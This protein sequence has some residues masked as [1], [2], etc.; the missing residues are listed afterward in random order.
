MKRQQWC[1][2][3]H[4]QML[5]GRRLPRCGLV[6]SEQET[7]GKHR[8]LDAKA[9]AGKTANDRPCPIRIATHFEHC[10]LIRSEPPIRSAPATGPGS[11]WTTLCGPTF[12]HTRI[13]AAISPATYVPTKTHSNLTTA[14]PTNTNRPNNKT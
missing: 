6:R 3:R 9:Q 5:D 2:F 4:I 11:L 13:G 8:I 14:T 1:D 7:I 10:Y 12:T